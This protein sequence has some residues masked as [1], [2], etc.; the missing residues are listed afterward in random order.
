[1]YQFFAYYIIKYNRA[2]VE[3]MES[4]ISSG[5]FN[6]GSRI[7]EIDGSYSNIDIKI[8][9]SLEPSEFLPQNFNMLHKD[10]HFNH[11]LSDFFKDSGDL[12]ETIARGAGVF[13]DLPMML[14][15]FKRGIYEEFKT[16]DADGNKISKR[17][18]VPVGTTKE[19]AEIVRMMLAIEAITNNLIKVETIREKFMSDYQG[20]LAKMNFTQDQIKEK[21]ITLRNSIKDGKINTLDDFKKLQSMNKGRVMSDKEKK[22]LG[23]I[24]AKMASAY[25]YKLESILNNRRSN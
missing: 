23:E 6:D 16:K 18:S 13:N 15:T 25:K 14:T 5:L 8:I 2:I 1:M 11:T 4:L 24:S 17:I 19:V 12:M 7:K 9:F 22:D 21:M 10:G 20:R 3:W